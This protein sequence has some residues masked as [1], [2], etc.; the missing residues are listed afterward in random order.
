MSSDKLTL[1]LQEA[2]QDALGFAT[3]SGHQQVEPEHLFY[4]LLRQQDSTVASVLDKLGIP[5]SSMIKEVEEDLHKKPA[6]S[7]ANP[8]VYLS[9]RMK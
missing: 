1:K 2:L 7:G 5:T 8:G 4:A 3:E 6:V 9:G